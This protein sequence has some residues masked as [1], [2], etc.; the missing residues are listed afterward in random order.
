MLSVLLTCGSYDL[1]VQSLQA[2]LNETNGNAMLWHAKGAV[3]L[4]QGSFREAAE[5]FERAISH[6]FFEKTNPMQHWLH[7]GLAS[8][9]TRDFSK[10]IQSVQAALKL[11]P[12]DY[13][14][15][16][17]LARALHAAGELDRSIE[18]FDAYL[19]LSRAEWIYYLKASVLFEQGKYEYTDFFLFLYFSIT[20]P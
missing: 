7:L 16:P 13:R 17:L 20:L 11:S 6:S 18:V 4:T 14:P 10:T 3:Y 19:A 9:Y 15:F 8:Y 2:A 5:C 12:E 1:A